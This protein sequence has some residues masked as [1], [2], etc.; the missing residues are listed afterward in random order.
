MAELM[1]TT[2]GSSKIAQNLY[3]KLSDLKRE[4]YSTL[5][6]ALALDQTQS[7][8]N[9]ANS[10]Y[11]NLDTLIVLYEKSVKLIENALEFFQKNKQDLSQLEGKY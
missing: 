5:D 8:L 11:A 3:D 7:T 1:A 10:N 6:Q 2:G 4:A 9:N